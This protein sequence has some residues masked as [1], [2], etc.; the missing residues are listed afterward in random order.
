MP[1]DNPTLT[2]FAAGWAAYQGMLA[3]TIAPLTPPQ[4]GLRA[5]P[6]QRPAWLIAAHIVATRVGWFQGMMGEGEATLAAYDP[7]DEDGAPPRT[8]AELVAGLDATWRMIQDGLDRW[9][10]EDLVA[11]FVRQ[12]GDRTVTRARGW[13]VWHVL[14]HDIHHGGE[15]SLTLGIHGLPTPDM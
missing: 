7:W 12:R 8:A 1:Q 9:T 2:P 6:A 15:L 10:P 13:V 3:D 5:A 4:L 14:E 11:P